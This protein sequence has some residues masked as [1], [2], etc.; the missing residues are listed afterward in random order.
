MRNKITLKVIIIVFYFLLIF[1]CLFSQL[2]LPETL[3]DR[4]VFNVNTGTWY[5]TIKQ[6]IYD[7]QTVDGHTLIVLEGTYHETVL[8]NKSLTIRGSSQELTIID[9]DSSGS[10]IYISADYVKVENLTVQN[11]G[12]FFPN[13]GIYVD[14]DNFSAS[15]VTVKNCAI[16]I[17]FY[18]SNGSNI[19]N[20]DVKHCLFGIW[21]DHSSGNNYVVNCNILSNKQYGVYVGTLSYSN[22]FKLNN[23]SNNSCGIGFSHSSSNSIFANNFLENSRDVTSYSS[24]NNWNYG[25]EGNFWGSH[26]LTDKNRDGIC[27]SPFVIDA[28]NVDPF[29]F[30]G[31]VNFFA[32]YHV[33]IVSNSTIRKFEY[34]QSNNSLRFLVY[35][36]LPNQFYGFCRVCIPH[37]LLKV[38]ELSVVI[39]KGNTIALHQNRSLYEN[40]THTWIYFAY[41]FNEAESHEVLIIPEIA[42]FGIYI[43]FLGCSAAILLIK[44]LKHVF[45]DGKCI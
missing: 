19:Y 8:V 7:S 45:R 25:A 40:G 32:E 16:G 43:T 36:L 29:P 30:A 35:K 26:N 12:Q 11:S 6:A 23:I 31:Q 1:I 24:I 22:T 17:Y 9:A 3:S 34:F 37:N 28:D 38:D 5:P 4:R 15:N 39:D 20:C 33:M 42:N 14:A 41:P 13:S 44:R 18:H 21:L 10:P 27:D 2:V